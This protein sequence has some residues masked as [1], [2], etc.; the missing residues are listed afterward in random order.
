MSETNTKMSGAIQI[1]DSIISLINDVG[2]MG[3]TQ[4]DNFL[5]RLKTEKEAVKVKLQELIIANAQNIDTFC[6][7]PQSTAS[8]TSSKQGTGSTVAPPTTAGTPFELIK[9]STLTVKT[10]TDAKI[11]QL[12]TILA[13]TNLSPNVKE[14]LE[15]L[16]AMLTTLSEET[17]EEIQGKGRFNRKDLTCAE[18]SKIVAK[19]DAILEKLAEISSLASLS[20]KVAEF[21]STA[22]DDFAALKSDDR[23]G[24]ASMISC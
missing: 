18:M 22:A 19:V 20:S 9:E 14:A 5:T 3:N 17:T 7:T 2:L 11:A 12:N 24:W 6:T 8:G 4:V 13:N 1:V 16:L 15:S 21:C 23:S 10:E